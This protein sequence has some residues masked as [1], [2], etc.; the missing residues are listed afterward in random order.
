MLGSG[1]EKIPH[2]QTVVVAEMERELI[3][4][5]T[6]AGLVTA[7]EQESKRAREQESKRAREQESKRARES[8]GGRVMTS[9]V[10][11]RSR[12]MLENGATRHQVAEVIGVG[13]KMIYKYFPV[14]SVGN[15]EDQ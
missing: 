7:R 4:V 9:E 3:V 10:V 13:V 14:A 2:I 8:R 12:R 15:F 5:R 6:R 11:E 1:S